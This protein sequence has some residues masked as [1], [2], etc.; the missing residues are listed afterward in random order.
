MS[1]HIGYLCKLVLSIIIIV[2]MLQNHIILF[3]AL[4]V[5]FLLAHMCC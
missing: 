3:A 4:H 2:K 5:V 1:P